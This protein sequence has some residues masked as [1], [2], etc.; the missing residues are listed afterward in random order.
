M[1]AKIGLAAAA[2][3]FFISYL[4]L[5][6]VHYPV[7]FGRDWQEGYRELVTKISHLQGDFEKVYVTD[8]DQVP[9]I[10]LLFYQKFDPGEFIRSGG[11]KRA[12]DKYVFSSVEESKYDK[13]RIL[14]AA[15]SWEKVDGKWLA[16]V[17]DAQGHHL[18]SLWEI[19]G[20]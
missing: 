13:G 4:H 11:T 1:A 16:A 20:Q 15:P 14:Y 8:I 12:F 5:L 2:F 17:N 7:K 19:N 6:F 9:Y 3:Y 10:Y 18:F